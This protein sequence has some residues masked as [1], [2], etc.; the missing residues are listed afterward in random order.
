MSQTLLESL[1]KKKLFLFSAFLLIGISGFFI[2]GGIKGA[3]PA[4]AN[5]HIANLFKTNNLKKYNFANPQ[6]WVWYRVN[7]PAENDKQG[8]TEEDFIHILH[9]GNKSQRITPENLVLA[10][11]IPHPGRNR[12][13]H[14]AFQFMLV[15]MSVQMN[16]LS[17]NVDLATYNPKQIIDCTL[18]FS[19]KVGYNDSEEG[20][21][22]EKWTELYRVE[23]QR[24]PL[25]CTFVRLGP[26]L[27][28]HYRHG[29]HLDGYYTC[30]D[31]HLFE[32]GSV[33]HKHYI[34]NIIFPA[35]QSN[36]HCLAGQENFFNG[37]HLTEIHQNGGYTI[38][39]FVAKT[40]MFPFIVAA[41][42]FFH[43]RIQRENRKRVLLE[44]AIVV[45][46]ISTLV[47]LLPIDWLTLVADLPFMLL[48]S[49]LRQG[50]FYAALL[51]FWTLFAGEHIMDQKKRNDIFAYKIEIGCI[52]CGCL[53]LLIFDLVERGTQLVN[54]FH[55]IW[56][57]DI[58]ETI[59]RI[60]IGVAG[61]A[62]VFYCLF[63]MR[64]LWLVHR[65]INIMKT[66]LPAMQ[67]HRRFF[68]ENRIYR[69]RVLLW[70]TLVIVASTVTCFIVDQLNETAW[71]FEEHSLNDYVLVSSALHFGMFGMWSGYVFA[72]TIF[73]SPSGRST[74][75]EIK[76]QYRHSEQ[77]L[78]SGD[79][80]ASLND[81]DEDE[82]QFRHP[83]T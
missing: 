79:V 2:L 49:D 30:D 69:F 31:Q 58:G 51:I 18:E 28:G 33:A 17:S 29:D 35:T 46:N 27:D 66:A 81:S 9:S 42:L 55:T 8:Y 76:V 75:K 32:L 40:I 54:P 45:L 19:A 11:K 21:D 39:L 59:A 65:N 38:S 64:L 16:F 20:T 70:A 78:A 4:T 73:Y 77:L 44:K 74:E 83:K 68:Y 12:V 50:L 5:I 25:K 41:F 15:V 56:K 24:R 13:M 23:N 6:D 48:V 43:L 61:A 3:D 22:I 60:F 14:K 36:M 47:L 71:K 10:T 67:E 52:C 57:K 82:I 62:S 80:D 7:N 1:S 34:V 72:V 37:V 26:Q 53:S 63:F